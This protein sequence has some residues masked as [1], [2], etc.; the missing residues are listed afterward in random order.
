MLMPDAGSDAIA[1]AAQDILGDGPFAA[2]AQQMAT[3]ISHYGGSAA[4]VA[5]L[6]ALA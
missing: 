4:A 3:A 5:A 2:G 6:E 1:A